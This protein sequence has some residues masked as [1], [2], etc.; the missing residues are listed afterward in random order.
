MMVRLATLC[1]VVASAVALDF[2]LYG[3]N[4]NSRQGPDWD[5]NKCKSQA[6]V[7]AD[8]VKIA[9]VA[10]RVR[11]FSLV[12]CNQGEIVLTAAKKAK[13]KVWLGMWVTKNATSVENEQLAMEK[14]IAKNLIDE[15]VLGLHVGSENIYRKDLT[16]TQAIAYLKQ[17]KTFL[18]GK[19]I[20]IPVTIADIADVIAQYPE[21]IDAVDVIQ[22]NS[23][24][25]WEPAA[26]ETSMVNFR[27]K[28]DLL[29]AAAKGKEIQIGE[30]GWASN[31]IN[32]NAS[33][34]S[35]ENQARY[36]VDL[37]NFANARKLKYYYFAAFDD[38]WKAK[39]DDNVDS[40][41]AH[42]GI[43]DSKGVLKPQFVNLKLAPSSVD[44]DKTN[45]TMTPPKPGA[46][47]LTTA[48]QTADASG[49][50]P[51]SMTSAVLAV[52]ATV[53]LLIV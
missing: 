23:F 13:L 30:T 25:F 16:A 6:Q 24:P 32:K 15:S 22:A 48:P 50:T 29:I 42:F 8:M 45:V 3:L 18:D 1:A 47:A 7:D 28:L 11:I 38:A 36:L 5:P 21:L 46:T 49:S 31:G 37:V 10:D 51:L 35:P 19:Q 34:V 9:A 17:I 20:T 27:F 39:Q 43:Y 26:I 53:A 12:D 33:V 40:V 44:A 2:K 4:Y 41:E 52:M 14:L